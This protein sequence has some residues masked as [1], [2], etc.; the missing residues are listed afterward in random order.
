MK[1]PTFPHVN[2][3]LHPEE[4]QQFGEWREFISTRSAAN[5]AHG[6]IDDADLLVDIINAALSFDPLFE[7]RVSFRTR[8]MLGE[9]GGIGRP[10][11]DF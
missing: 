1:K 7:Y 6:F 10:P 4:H 2:E 3:L 8:R 5:S 9:L 11:P